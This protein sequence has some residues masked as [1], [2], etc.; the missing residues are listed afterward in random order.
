MDRRDTEARRSRV[1]MDVPERLANDAGRLR[2]VVRGALG[3]PGAVVEVWDL[4]PSQST[5]SRSLCLL[6]GKAR[7]GAVEHSW[8][9]VLKVLRPVAD[10]DDPTHIFYWER[11]ALLY[12]SGFLDDLPAGLRAPRCYGW[13]EPGD[14]SV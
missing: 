12:H 14:G 4:V 10:Q 13:D 5:V 3:E 1:A 8:R 11:E 7:V 9:V 6:N 2:E